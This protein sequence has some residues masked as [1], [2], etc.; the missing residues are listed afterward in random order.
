VR[1]CETSSSRV[2]EAIERILSSPA[3]ASAAAAEPPAT[4]EATK[5][6]TA[7]APS[8]KST[9]TPTAPA[10][11][12]ADRKR[13]EDRQ[14]TATPAA[15]PAAPRHRAE[16]DDRDER[17]QEQHLNRNSLRHSDPNWPFC[18]PIDVTLEIRSD[19]AVERDAEFPG[20]L[21]RDA[22]REKERSLAVIPT[23]ERGGRGSAEFASITV[24]NES[25]CPAANFDAAASTAIGVGFFRNDQDNDARI[26]HAVARF[27]SRADAPLATNLAGDIGSVTTT[28]SPPVRCFSAKAMRLIR[29]SASG[30]STF[31]ASTTTSAAVGANPRGGDGN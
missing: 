30:V 11:V 3:R 16:Q 1:S 19:D 27:C 10:A 20:K 14:T 23:L 5:P 26:A 4:T 2:I 8:T 15:T 24:A 9:A 25:F 17:E 21:S 18:G 12:P 29:S 7:E 31:A 28:I 6:T 22:G 13:H